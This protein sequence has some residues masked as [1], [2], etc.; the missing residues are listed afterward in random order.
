METNENKD[1]SVAIQSI[2]RGSTPIHSP[3]VLSKKYISTPPISPRILL[4]KSPLSNGKKLSQQSLNLENSPSAILVGQISSSNNSNTI[5]SPNPFENNKPIHYQ[6]SL[7]S[8]PL[9]DFDNSD[10]RIPTQRQIAQNSFINLNDS[11][12]SFHIN[13]S[14]IQQLPPSPANSEIINTNNND[15]NTTTENQETTTTT[16]NQNEA[17]LQQQLVRVSLFSN[18]TKLNTV[19]AFF[20]I[21]LILTTVIMFIVGFMK[22]NETIIFSGIITSPIG[23]LIINH[24]IHLAYRRSRRQFEMLTAEPPPPPDPSTIPS[25][26]EEISIDIQSS[27]SIGDVLQKYE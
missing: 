17:N 1:S 11:T 24:A 18:F 22:E 15:E 2:S 3:I 12:N 20:G 5:N 10:Y 26:L 16:D 14:S 19:W 21:S 23:F 13:I 9:D 7:I 25:K 4:N 8:I 6:P 27:P